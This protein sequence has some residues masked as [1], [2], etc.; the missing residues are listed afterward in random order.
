MELD[1][2]SHRT[3]RGTTVAAKRWIVDRA[4]DGDRAGTLRV[5]RRAHP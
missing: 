4:V 2:Q 5:I 1:L 3:S